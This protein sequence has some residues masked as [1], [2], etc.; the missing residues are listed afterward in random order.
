MVHFNVYHFVPTARTLGRGKTVRGKWVD[1]ARENGTVVRSR[2]VAMEVA[3]EMRSDTFSGT[4]PLLMVRYV[5]SRAASI[6]SNATKGQQRF[7]TIYDVIC[8]FL[9]ARMDSLMYA[10]LPAG[11][12]PPNTRAQLDGAVYGT[13]RASSLWG[14]KIGDILVND[15]GFTRMR[16]CPKPTTTRSTTFLRLC[17]GTT[18][19]VS[20][21]VR[22]AT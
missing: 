11:L 6:P 8:A 12:S 21:R 20:R 4:P 16:N 3:Y 7:I 17:T 14:E 22:G 13:R 15:Y 1:E 2:L 18:S 5:I 19:S 9:H 10:I